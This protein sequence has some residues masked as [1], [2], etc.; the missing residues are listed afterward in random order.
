LTL[1]EAGRTYDERLRGFQ[2]RGLVP[3]ELPA[4]EE[5]ATGRMLA[6]L[7]ICFVDPAHPAARTLGGARWDAAVWAAHRPTLRAYDARALV[8]GVV[9]P[10]LHFIAPVPFG[11]AMSAAMADAMTASARRRVH[12][13]DAGHLPWLEQPLGF[14]RELERFLATVT[15]P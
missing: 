4:W 5:D 9:A 13:H 15:N 3:A 2:R 11:P 10:S 12:L 6:L 1:R 7:P 8:A 14:R